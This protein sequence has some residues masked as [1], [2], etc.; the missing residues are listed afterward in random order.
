MSG[1]VAGFE[2]ATHLPLVA[3]KVDERQPKEAAA[4]EKLVE[5]AVQQI[6]SALR[7]PQCPRPLPR[8]TQRKAELRL[9]RH[10]PSAMDSPSPT[11]VAGAT[12]LDPIREQASQLEA[13]ACLTAVPE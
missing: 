7:P 12:N 6:D 2:D 9:L 10:Q 4:Q 13:E 3:N 1:L 5:Q 8:Q 11:L